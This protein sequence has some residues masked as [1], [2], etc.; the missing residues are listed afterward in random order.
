MVINP[1]N[2]TG[3]SYPREVLQK[4]V[5]IAARH[6]LLLM[7][8]EI[9]DGILYDEAR[10][11]PLVRMALPDGVQSL[12]QAA[13]RMGTDAA[14]TYTVRPG[15][16]LSKIAARSGVPLARLFAINGLTGKSILRPGQVLR[17]AP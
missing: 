13:V 8:D 12:E 10:F 14:Q 17:L 15:D 9:Y 6:K 4:L 11:V 5:D 7:A 2:P 3:A 1:N 16:T